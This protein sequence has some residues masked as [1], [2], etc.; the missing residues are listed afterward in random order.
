MQQL[1]DV[2]T[3]LMNSFWVAILL[4]W[5]A[6]FIDAVGYLVLMHVFPAHMSGNTVAAASHL[7]AG[8]FSEVLRRGFPIPMFVL[9]VFW[10]A[11]VGR[12]MQLKAVAR[13]FAPSFIAETMLL[14][15]FVAL[16]IR[17]KPP[18]HISGIRAY[19][20]VALLALAM[21]LQNATLRCARGM[22]VRTTFISGMLVNMAE[23]AASF[24]GDAVF[25]HTA[26]SRTSGSRHRQGTRALKYG[27]LW[28][29]M[30]AGAVCGAGMEI[31]WGTVVLFLPIGGLLAI[32]LHEFTGPIS[33]A[34]Q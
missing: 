16:T 15:L 8:Q 18:A 4:A 28:C 19:S 12:A 34:A 26:S 14:V 10:G 25:R 24:F 30:F 2:Q 1:Q 13:R 9:G 22:A 11:L 17:V 5:I 3:I 7:G 23:G 32:I 31:S 29:A 27:S 33:Q 6:G 20:L 21:G